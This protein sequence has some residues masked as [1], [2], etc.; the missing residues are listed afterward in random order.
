VV[1]ALEEF[2]SRGD[3]L[4]ISEMER[5]DGVLPEKAWAWLDRHKAPKTDVS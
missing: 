5:V 4:L 3:R 1:D 2:L